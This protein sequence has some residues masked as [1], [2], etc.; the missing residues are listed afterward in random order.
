MGLG[1]CGRPPPETS[2]WSKRDMNGRACPSAR[3]NKLIIR[4]DLFLKKVEVCTMSLGSVDLVRR[5]QE[6]WEP[7]RQAQWLVRE[8]G[9]CVASGP[10]L[11]RPHRSAPSSITW[12]VFSLNS[13]RQAT[14]ACEINTRGLRAKTGLR[15]R[16]VPGLHPAPQSF[17]EG[18]LMAGGGSGGGS[19][20]PPGVLRCLGPR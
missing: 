17:M 6:L 20:Q 12:K 5:R 16:A 3:N 15:G 14:Q 7:H 9:A 18:H 19:T 8:P 11:L 13:W 1:Q 2:V 10:H 4:K